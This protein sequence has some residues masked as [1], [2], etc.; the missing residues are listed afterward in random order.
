MTDYQLLARIADNPDF[1]CICEVVVKIPQCFKIQD[2]L[3]IKDNKRELRI[4]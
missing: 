4:L 2:R 1:M 3:L